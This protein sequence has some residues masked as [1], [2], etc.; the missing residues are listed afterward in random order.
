MIQK[1]AFAALSACLLLTGA[2]A[3]AAGNA[4]E[5]KSVSWPHDGPFG[6]YDRAAAQRGLQVYREV[7]SSCHSLRLVAF[8]TLTDIGLSEDEVKAIAAEYQIEDG[9]DEAGD[10][11]ERDGKPSDYFPS[12]FANANAARSAN[13]GALPPDLSLIV[14]AREGHDDYVYSILTGYSDPPADVKLGS[15]MNYNPYFAGHQIAMAPPLFDEAVE[16]ADGTP[17]TVDQM[18]HDVVT[19]LTWAGDPHMEARRATGVK[20]ILFLIVLTLVLYAVKRKVWSDLH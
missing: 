1:T 3:F 13:N 19:F 14:K 20:A 11:Y 16:Y 8:R 6:T 4:E 12:P 18:A 15:G 2:T 9:P 17:A 7:C 10:M 5:P